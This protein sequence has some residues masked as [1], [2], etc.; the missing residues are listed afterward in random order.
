MREAKHEDYLTVGDIIHNYILFDIRLKKARKRHILFISDISYIIR[1]VK[2]IWDLLSIKKVEYYKWRDFK[3]RA[4]KSDLIVVIHIRPMVDFLSKLNSY[5]LEKGIQ[6]IKGMF[7]GKEFIY[8]PF[9]L[10]NEGPC[11][12]CYLLLKSYNFIFDQDTIKQVPTSFPIKSY[13]KPWIW[14][15][16]LFLTLNMINWIGKDLYDEEEISEYILDLEKLSVKNT[17]LLRS[18]ICPSCMRKVA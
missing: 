6:L 5:C 17:P 14:T 16:L 12:N 1:E 8:I 7:R 2:M 9:L 11:Y 15:S 3:Y 4:N 13:P 10:P 18:P